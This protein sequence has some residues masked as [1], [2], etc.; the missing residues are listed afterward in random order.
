MAA[1]ALAVAHRSSLGVAGL[2][3]VQRFDIQATVLSLF[4]VVQLSVY[5]AAQLPVGLALDRFGS[6]RMIATGAFLMAVGQLGMALA[7][8]LPLAITMRVLIGFGDAMTFVSVIRLV[9]Q[10]FPARRVPLMTQLTG[11]VGQLGQVLSA[12]PFV[13]VLRHLSWGWAFGS[14]SVIG[15]LAGFFVITLVRDRPT[16]GSRN[17]PTVMSPRP[18]SSS[19]GAAL[20]NP[21]TWLGFWTHMVTSFSTNVFALLWGYP[22]LISGQGLSP[23]AASALLTWNVVVA[24]A[25]GPI[26]GEFTARHPLRRSWAVIVISVGVLIGWLIVIIA[27]QPLPLWALVIFVSLVAV[28]GPGSVIGFDYARSFNSPNRLGAATGLVNVGGFI[29]AVVSVLA[30]GI[31]LDAVSGGEQFTLNGFRVAFLVIVVI[32]LIAMVNLLISRRLTRKMMA[33]D[34]VIVPPITTVIKRRRPQS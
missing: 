10:W 5:A 30:I 27:S 33:A 18:D 2:D 8:T 16:T 19:V 28:G 29:G 11:I 32:W 14:L 17:E 13:A 7:T 25:A 21:G 1:Y 20:R 4:A 24:I 15:L 6:R 3:L 31:I 34:G 26:I 23:T 9:P 12:V 22:F